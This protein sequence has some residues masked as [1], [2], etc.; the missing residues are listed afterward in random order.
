MKKVFIGAAAVVV[1]ISIM[2]FLI[3]G[4]LLQSAYEATKKYLAA[5]YGFKNVD[6]QHSLNDR[7]VL[8]FLHLF[9]GLR[10]KG[11]C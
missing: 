8:L 4:L 1:A 9:E 7:F 6:I 2:D 11:H 10:R 3:H 5:G